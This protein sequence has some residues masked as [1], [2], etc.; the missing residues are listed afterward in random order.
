M[1]YDEELANRLRALVSGEPGMTEKRMFGGLAMLR[2]GH[3]AV[4]IR[5]AGGLLVRIDP[6]DMATAT[7]KPGAE[8]AYMGGRMMAGWI[9][10]APSAVDRTADLRGWVKRGMSAAGALPLK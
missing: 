9:F 6:A 1:A 10:V 5:G 7:A 3:I 2:H 4:A 8:Q